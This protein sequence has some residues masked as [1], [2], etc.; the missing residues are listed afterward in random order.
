MNLDFFKYYVTTIEM[1]NISQAA[2][3]LYLSR[4]ALS[5]SIHHAEQELGIKLISFEKQKLSATKEGEILYQ[6]AKS[7]LQLWEN[8]VTQIKAQGNIEATLHVGFGRMSQ[9]VWP[10]DH[11]KEFELLHPRIQI[12]SQV[13]ASDQLIDAL[14][15]KELD[16]IVTNACLP[17]PDYMTETLLKRPM[18]ALIR[19]DDPLAKKTV[20]RPEDIAERINIFYPEDKVGSRYFLN[21]MA[22]LNLFPRFQFCVDSSL[23]TVFH[24]VADTSGVFLT[25]AIF[26]AIVS[27]AQ[28]VCVPFETGLPEAEYN[29]DIRLIYARNTPQL[30]AIR[31]YREDLLSHMKKDFLNK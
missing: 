27:P 22:M 8:T 3:A 30:P 5:K 28:C 25:S 24:T 11:S 16:V 6:N 14:I 17:D 13:M 21:M 19:K 9:L 7:I 4:Q 10:S 20:L 18:Y 29:M 31:N 26:N 15:K 1:G 23:T 12:L 2:N